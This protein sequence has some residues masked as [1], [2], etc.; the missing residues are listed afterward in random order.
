MR[1]PGPKRNSVVRGTRLFAL[2]LV[3]VVTSGI[4]F[5]PGVARA[6]DAP[7]TSIHETWDGL[8][9]AHVHAGRVDYKA[10]ASDRKRLD[11]YLSALRKTSYDA[12]ESMTGRERLAFWIDAYNA[13]TVAL[14]LDHYPIDS[15]WKVTPFWQRVM[16]GPFVLDFIPLGHLA[17]ELDKS[18]LSLNDL[19]HGIMRKKFKEPRIHFVIVCA[20][21]GCP[22]L[23]PHA[24]VGSRLDQQLDEAARGFLRDR[25]KN[26]YD[27]ATGTLYLSPIFDWFAADFEPA[28]GPRAFFERYGPDADVA[29]LKQADHVSI[30]FTEYDWSLNE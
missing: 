16:G 20:S 23:Q 17:P 25:A 10:F 19:E 7:T 14:V 12:F 30:E 3:L 29:A 2:Q 6:A 26:R 5:L 11:A 28:G 9:Q 21:K 24:Y 1:Q 4:V 15:I 18:S 8:L 13:F 22:A 27:E